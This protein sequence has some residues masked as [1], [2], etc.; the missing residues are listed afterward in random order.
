MA[1]H[2]LLIILTTYSRGYNLSAIVDSI[3]NQTF[4]DYKILICDDL[5]PN[6]PA[7]ICKEII[8]KYPKVDIE[9]QRNQNRVG[10]GLNL[11]VAMGKEYNKGF[12]YM[13]VFQDDT[14]YLDNTFLSNAIDLLEKN[15]DTVYCA[16]ITSRNGVLGELLP[17]PKESNVNYLKISGLDFWRNWGGIA[18]QWSACVF[19]YLN[20]MRYWLGARD[21]VVN[22]DSLCLLNI[23]MR[24]KI[25]IWNKHAVELAYN[26]STGGY[27]NS[28]NYKD[29]IKRFVTA[30][31]YYKLA[32]EEAVKSGVARQEADT[33]LLNHQVQIAIGS[34]KQIGSNQELLKEFMLTLKNY[35]QNLMTLILGAVL[36]AEVR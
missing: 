26:K 32:S 7:E 8:N 17:I 2:K 9:Y 10:E 36:M 25:I 3:V 20:L 21:K 13:V 5:S 6:N 30:E 27:I 33:W 11:A 18:T 12:K 15:S 24:G 34:I 4:K 1:Q 29:P 23:A 19:R 28:P 22:G 31:K 35:D 16:G 14:I